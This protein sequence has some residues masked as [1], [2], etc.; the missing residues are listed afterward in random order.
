MLCES[1]EVCRR[2]EGLEFYRGEL[3][4]I[5][6]IVTIVVLG[7]SMRRRF[8]EDIRDSARPVRSSMP[9]IMRMN[10]S[11]YDAVLLHRGQ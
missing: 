7:Y 3:T 11:P 9:V 1:D 6:R 2:D 4:G 5:A 10:S 8:L